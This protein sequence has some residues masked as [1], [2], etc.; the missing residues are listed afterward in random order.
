MHLRQLQSNSRSVE[1]KVKNNCCPW[2][3]L[4]IWEL[5]RVSNKLY[6]RWK[7]N[8]QDQPLKNMLD[9]ANKNL[10]NCKK[11]AKAAYYRRI[12]S[13]DNPKALWSRI[14]EL[15]G[16][17]ANKCKSISLIANGDELIDPARVGDAFNDFFSSVGENLSST[18]KT[19]GD[20][21]KFSTMENCNSSFSWNLHQKLR[22]CR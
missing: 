16:N 4:E 7:R 5:S 19:D 17:K 8:R 18:L 10:A 15:I 20:V 12:L 21:N 1:I 6:Q 3:N 13:A 14:N 22:S 9:R 2:F 11:R